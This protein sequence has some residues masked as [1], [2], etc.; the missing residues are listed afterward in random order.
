[1]KTLAMIQGVNAASSMDELI[2]HIDQ[3]Q[4]TGCEYNEFFSIV[5]D[6]AITKK[7]DEL[8]PKSRSAWAW[9][10]GLI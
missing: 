8:H 10:W 6:E 1:M 9:L 4:K 2:S 5:L 7:A 3:I